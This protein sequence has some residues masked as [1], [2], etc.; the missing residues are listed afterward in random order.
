MPTPARHRAPIALHRGARVYI[1]LP[2]RRDADAFLAAVR[3]SKRLH[4]A[5]VRA[6]QAVAGFHDYVARF[7]LRT[8]RDPH[9]ATHAGLLVRRI[10]DDTIVGVFNFSEIVRGSFHSAYLGYYAFAPHAG[11]GHMAEGLALALKFAFR[12]LRLHRVEVNVQPRNARSHA[13]VL[14][15]GFVREGFSRRYLRIAGR[16]RDHVRYAILAED[17]RARRKQRR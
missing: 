6:P 9:T 5:W 1:C 16:W 8:R 3:A 4:G 7:G 2:R 17:W 13:L 12:T 14:G 11:S 10:D 15:A